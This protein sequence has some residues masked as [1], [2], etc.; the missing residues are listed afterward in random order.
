L[1]PG[2]LFFV[3]VRW[4]LPGS[5]APIR[6]LC[7]SSLVVIWLTWAGASSVDAMMPAD[8]MG[9][10]NATCVSEIVP[11]LSPEE[12]EILG[13]FREPS[14]S[15]EEAESILARYDHIDPDGAIPR[16][17]LE[18][19]LLYFDTNLDLIPNKRFLTV[20][21][22]SPA[23]RY[24]RFHIIQMETG[25]VVSLHA[26]HGQGSDPGNTGRATKFSN[27]PNSKMSSLGFYRTAEVYDGSHGMSLRLDGLSPTNS[28]A[29]ERAIVIHG[30][31]YV[32]DSD[33]KPGRSWGCPA[34]SME[35]R[36]RVINPIKE[37]SILFAGQA[38]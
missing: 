21:D 11:P 22:F 29:R 25:S 23:S 3:S 18:T 31:D 16:D 2:P 7:M 27:T 6:A 38:Q 32:H 34:I 13:R 36:A 37:G 20:F 5:G 14:V 8:A 15:D 35:N 33:V 19:A 4:F 1:N 24:S 26:A 12:Q 28:K 17:L 10:E 30:A 9:E